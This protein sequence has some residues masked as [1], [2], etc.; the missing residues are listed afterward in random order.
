MVIAVCEKCYEN[1]ECQEHREEK[2]NFD[3][4]SQVSEN[5]GVS[6]AEGSAQAEAQRSERT[7]DPLRQCES[8]QWWDKALS[9]HV[10]LTARPAN[11]KPEA[12][13]LQTCA[14]F[15]S[16]PLS[17]CPSPVPAGWSCKPS[18]SQLPRFA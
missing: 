9:L 7:E 15:C 3:M 16:E 10:M 8:E 1:S 12:Q 18:P 6:Q 17:G 14:W 2:V 5:A 11:L 13:V 4:K